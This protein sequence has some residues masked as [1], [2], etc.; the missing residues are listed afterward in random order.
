MSTRFGLLSAARTTAT[1]AATA[2]AANTTYSCEYARLLSHNIA[3][4]V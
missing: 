3:L 4:F 1:A 2:T